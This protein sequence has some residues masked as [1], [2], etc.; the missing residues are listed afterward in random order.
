MFVFPVRYYV[1]CASTTLT[2]L[3]L[4]T[5]ESVY[6]FNSN[7]VFRRILHEMKN[8]WD[9][10]DNQ[11]IYFCSI[12]YFYEKSWCLWDNAEKYGRARGASDDILQRVRT[13]WW[14][15]G[16]IDTF[17]EYLILIAFPWQQ[18]LRER[19]SMSRLYV[20]CLFLYS[21][22]PIIAF[23][24]GSAYFWHLSLCHANNRLSIGCLLDRASLW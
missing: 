21:L 11:N 23:N 13:A 22:V 24:D 16:V 20:H 8:F 12:V 19:A 3:I 15:A 7:P 1:N 5:V 18:W 17:R 6:Y 9:N 2:V 10:K 14:M 4:H